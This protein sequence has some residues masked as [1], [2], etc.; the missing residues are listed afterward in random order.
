MSTLNVPWRFRPFRNIK[1]AMTI[2]IGFRCSDGILLCADTQHTCPGIMKTRRTKAYFYDFP[3]NGSKVAFVFSGSVE[4][5]KM[6]IQRI[7]SAVGRIRKGTLDLDS[8]HRETQRELEEIYA[9]H[10]FPHP[11]FKDV[12][13]PGFDLLMACF[14]GHECGSD[15]FSTCESSVCKVEDS[16]VCLGAGTYLA[17]FL[18]KN[19]YETGTDLYGAAGLALGVLKKVKEHVDGCGGYSEMVYLRYD[20]SSGQILDPEQFEPLSDLDSI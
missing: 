17:E 4:Y 10:I 15:L 14:A 20:G 2:A 1:K 8:V 9:K 19:R 18:L 3:R 11:R 5:A 16:Y 13:G 6:A 12:D 7:S